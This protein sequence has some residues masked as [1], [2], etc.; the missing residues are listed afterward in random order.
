MKRSLKVVYPDSR[1]HAA[2]Y[3]LFIPVDAS[4]SDFSRLLGEC[5]S[6][7]PAVLCGDLA[8]MRHFIAYARS[9]K[10]TLTFSSYE[11]RI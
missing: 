10:I 7:E 8:T 6:D 4:V 5:E 2:P 1:A 3:D 11:K 9:K